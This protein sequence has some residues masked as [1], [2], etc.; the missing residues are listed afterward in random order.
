MAQ[1]SRRRGIAPIVIVI[2]VVAVMMMV[3]IT[4]ASL[5]GGGMLLAA[6]NNGSGTPAVASAPSGI[7]EAEDSADEAVKAAEQ[8]LAEANQ[9]FDACQAAKGGIVPAGTERQ[10]L[11]QELASVEAEID[12]ADPGKP[13]PADLEARQAELARA[14]A[15]ADQAEYQ[16]VSGYETTRDAFQAKLAAADAAISGA[17]GAVESL[18]QQVRTWRRDAGAAVDAAQAPAG[19]DP[20]QPPAAAPSPDDLGS[21][22][23]ASVDDLQE[24]VDQLRT[25]WIDLKTRSRAEFPSSG[26]LMVA[27]GRTGQVPDGPVSTLRTAVAVALEPGTGDFRGRWVVVEAVAQEYDAETTR[28]GPTELLASALDRLADAYPRAQITVVEYPGRTRS[29]IESELEVG[30]PLP[31]EQ[32]VDDRLNDQL[33]PPPDAPETTEDAEAPEDAEPT[34]AGDAPEAPAPEET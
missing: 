19:A 7:Q 3:S 5:I 32:G 16:A 11:Q 17:E 31:G 10:S 21:S 23:A 13:P 29:E 9:A 20:N 15:T 4:I 27:D 1:G 33:G 22:Y 34:A 2:A 30:R 14:L 25:Q 26:E 8:A 12:A 18:R 28:E 6:S 24:R